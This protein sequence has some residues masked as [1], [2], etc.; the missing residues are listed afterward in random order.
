MRVL[1][2]DFA[3]YN[4]S[5]NDELL[6]DLGMSELCKLSLC[7]IP[8][9]IVTLNLCNIIWMGKTELN[10]TAQHCN[11]QVVTLSDGSCS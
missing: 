8:F 9:L 3:K 4:V 10:H 11:N 7:S 2:S 5:D 6:D 1:K